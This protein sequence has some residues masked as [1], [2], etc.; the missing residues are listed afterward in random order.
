MGLSGQRAIE[1]YGKWSQ[2]FKGNMALLSA[3]I[4][5]FSIKIDDATKAQPNY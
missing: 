3:T 4:G 2:Q 5:Q 1:D